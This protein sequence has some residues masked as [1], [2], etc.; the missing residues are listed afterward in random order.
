VPEVGKLAG[1]E[2]D[3]VNAL[4]LHLVRRFEQDR[5]EPLDEDGKTFLTVKHMQRLL[6]GVG[7]R[8]TG[9]KAAREASTTS[10]RP[11]SS[12]TRARSRR[13]GSAPIASR[14]RRSSGAGNR[15]PVCGTSTFW[16]VQEVEGGWDAQP[17]PQRRYWWRVFRAV[18]L[19]AV[20]RRIACCAARMRISPRRRSSQRVCPHGQLVKG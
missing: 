20:L 19:A 9:E 11:G 10:S 16:K 12:R 18:A 3:A 8:C 7:A 4:A 13:R 1:D 15:C 5:F 17:T 14:R 2:R 6:R